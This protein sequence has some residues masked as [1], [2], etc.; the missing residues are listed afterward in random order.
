MTMTAFSEQQRDPAPSIGRQLLTK[1][2]AITL[3]FWIIKVLCTT[4]GETAADFL[5]TH[6]HLSLTGTTCIMGALLAI[7]LFFQFRS[8][9]YVPGIYWL[10]VVFISVVG[11]RVTGNLHDNIGVS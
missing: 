1:V 7:A 6:L 5:N 10:A 3:Y 9:K 4:V 8:S 2:P 11:P